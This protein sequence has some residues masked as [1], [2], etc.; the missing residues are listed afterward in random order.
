M[1]R[2][3]SI[4][5]CCRCAVS[6]RRCWPVSIPPWPVSPGWPV[7]P[8]GPVH[9]AGPVLNAELFAAHG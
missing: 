2:C 8:A 4:L 9:P 3:D 1:E 6:L 7:R 5:R